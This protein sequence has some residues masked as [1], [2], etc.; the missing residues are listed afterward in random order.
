MAADSLNSSFCLSSGFFLRRWLHFALVLILFLNSGCIHLPSA[1]TKMVAPE[2]SGAFALNENSLYRIESLAYQSEKYPLDDFFARLKIGEFVAAFR[3][4]NLTYQASNTQNKALKELIEA[5]YSPVLVK[6][7]NRT[8]R[9]MNFDESYFKLIVENQRYAA[10]PVKSLPKEFSHFSLQSTVANVYNV[11]V[12]VVA[13]LA[14]LVAIA[15]ISPRGGG[16]YGGSG[17]NLGNLLPFDGGERILN[18]TTIAT[19][20]DYRDHLIKETVLQPGQTSQGLLFFKT[21]SADL[22][23]SWVEIQP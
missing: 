15:A 19:R 17:G 7:T 23:A 2:T 6:F 18:D 3:S 12:V 16:G 21:N 1:E 22:T 11:T 14:L 20:I 9:E 4:I 13:S 5:G 8:D 10:L